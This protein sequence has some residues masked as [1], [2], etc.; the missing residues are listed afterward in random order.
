MAL[1]VYPYC[2]FSVLC[3]Q[4]VCCMF[5]FW[6][7]IHSMENVDVVEIL[8]DCMLPLFGSFFQRMIGCNKGCGHLWTKN[9]N[10]P[11]SH[12]LPPLIKNGGTLSLLACSTRPFAWQWLILWIASLWT[13]SCRFM[14]SEGDD[15]RFSKYEPMSHFFFARG[16]C[17]SM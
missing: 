11:S 2:N 15:F 12:A 14:L 17:R 3:F 4:L 8:H 5:R 7:D 10:W 1:P 13:L 16:P 9:L 6:L